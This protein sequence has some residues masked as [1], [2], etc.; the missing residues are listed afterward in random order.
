[1]IRLVIGNQTGILE[2]N[3]KK[4]LQVLRQKYTF[5]IPGAEYSSA[6]RQR[7]WDGK[8][9]FFT[10]TGRFGTGMMYHLINDLEY[11][12]EPYEIEDNRSS[13]DLQD[14]KI[15]GIDYRYYQDNVVQE[16]LKYKNGIVL[17]PT[18]AGKTV[19]LAGLLK[20]LENETGLI[21]FT[22]KQLLKQTYDELTKWGFDVGVAFGDGVDIKPITLCT[23]QSVDKVVDT[24]LKTSSFIMFDEV[25]EFS[26]G[27]M[28]TKVVKSFPN[29]SYRFGFTATMPK[30]PISK[31]NVISY[32]GPTRGTADA[33]ELA[34]LGFLTPPKIQV[35]KLDQETHPD[36]LTMSYQEIYDKYVIN[37]KY[38]NDY[39]ANMVKEIQKKPS[40][41]LIITKNLDHAEAL[42][43]MIPGSFLLRGANSLDERD[44]KVQEFVN[45]ESSV[46]I[47]TVIFQTGINIPEITHLINARG[48]KS[49]IATL[50]AAGRALRKHKS[51][52][53]VY[54]YDFLDDAPYLLQH[55]KQRVRSYK[56][57][58]FEVYLID[59]KDPRRE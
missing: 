51:K 9:S 20:A 44:A 37:N 5:K 29:A 1:M 48:L 56:S 34:E 10:P 35:V 31:L 52:K 12:G 47:G 28:A 16:C 38:R 30:D 7:R 2:T 42:H 39:I 14:Y 55:A 23:I 45:Q 18:G 13:A 32:L 59:E 58:G 25:Q 4:L 53:Q 54:I 57:L 26:K 3:N 49:E 50:Q 21:F 33:V 40:K 6:Y 43:K 11:L 17:A 24:H 27:K 46:I 41:T 22:K 19:I 8:K 15:E 36:D